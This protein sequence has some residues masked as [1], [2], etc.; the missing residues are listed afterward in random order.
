MVM[1][2]DIGGGVVVA[3]VRVEVVGVV[4]GFGVAIVADVGRVVCDGEV[5]RL[6]ALWLCSCGACMVISMAG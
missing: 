2:W 1:E 3:G 6:R 5:C 4:E